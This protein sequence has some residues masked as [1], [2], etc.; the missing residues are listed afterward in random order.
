MS[1]STHLP[2]PDHS[3]KVPH[4]V[5]GLLFLGL[6]VVWALVASDTI[7]ADSVPLIGPGVLIAAGVVGLVASL[8]NGRNRRGRE[9]VVVDDP[10]AY[11]ETY[12]DTATYG[13]THD[14]TTREIR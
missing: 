9:Q 8:A 2:P 7:D 13:E 11:T 3:V 5:F 14:E 10:D 1:Q 4:L 12:G 6:A